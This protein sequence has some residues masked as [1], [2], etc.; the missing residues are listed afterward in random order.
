LALSAVVAGIL[1]VVALVSAS[2]GSTSTASKSSPTSSRGD[3][4]TRETAVAAKDRQA[5][6]EE[7][8]ALAKLLVQ[9][10]TEASSVKAL[11]TEQEVLEHKM[12]LLET[13]IEQKKSEVTFEDG[14]TVADFNFG[15]ELLKLTEEYKTGKK[16][17]ETHERSL[18]VNRE[19]IDASSARI[20]ALKA[21]QDEQ[22]ADLAKAKA[23][24]EQT[25]K[26]VESR[27]KQAELEAPYD[28]KKADPAPAES[29]SGK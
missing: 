9:A 19:A 13:A 29:K 17:L 6:L 14:K 4:Q 7:N 15:K 2:S 25:R 10:E 12:M 28:D 11:R 26:Y 24:L 18:K 27:K 3:D 20:A 1:W 23:Q 22:G 5:L 21:T 16:N 8:R